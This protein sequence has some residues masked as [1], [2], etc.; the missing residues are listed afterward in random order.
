MLGRRS[1]LASLSA[2]LV[3]WKTP[4][5][6][7]AIIRGPANRLDL[8]PG[9][10]IEWWQDGDYLIRHE[11]SG[12][13]RRAESFSALQLGQEF[14]QYEGHGVLKSYGAITGKTEFAGRGLWFTQ[15]TAWS[16]LDHG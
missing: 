14:G 8:T 9:E 7:I 3:W 1:F 2:L 11:M 16:T 15:N 12:Q 6:D 5:A 10:P 13:W 4:P